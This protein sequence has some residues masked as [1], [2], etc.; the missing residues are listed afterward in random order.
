MNAVAVAALSAQLFPAG[1]VAG[2]VV[3]T[4]LDS[5]GSPVGSPQSVTAG[6]GDG[7]SSATFSSVPAGTYTISAVRQDGNGASLGGATSDP[8]TVDVPV[9]VSV[10]VPSGVSVTQQ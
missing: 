5:S 1:T 7:S 8:F 9:T 4:L 6:A 10:T 3:F 2:N